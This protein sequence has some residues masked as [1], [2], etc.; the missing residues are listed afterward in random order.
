M[1]QEDWDALYAYA[2]LGFAWTDD[3]AAGDLFMNAVPIGRHGQ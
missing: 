3:P 1:Y 2:T